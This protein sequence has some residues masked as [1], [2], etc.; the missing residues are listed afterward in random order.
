MHSRKPIPAR[1]STIIGPPPPA[2]PLATAV[3][4]RSGLLSDSAPLGVAEF[5]GLSGGWI[6]HR[7]KVRRGNED[8]C[9]M[10]SG[11]ID[12]EAADCETPTEVKKSTSPWLV[13]VS[14]GI[15]GHLAGA[16]ASRAV[17]SEI[18]QCELIT[19]DAI[20]KQIENLNKTLCE[21]GMAD[22]A[23]ASMGATIAGLGCGPTGLFMFHV[24]DSRIYREE[25]GKLELLTRDDSEAE[26]LID[27]GLLERS[28]GKRPGFLH[29]LTQAVGGRDEV[30]EIDVHVQAIAVMRPTRFLICT[31]GLTDMIQLADMEHLI[32]G[33]EGAKEQ[34]AALFAGAMEAGG[35][36][37]ITIAVVDVT[38][39]EAV[40]RGER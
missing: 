37:N 30:L 14:D 3:V 8:A 33:V 25:E 34:V 17:V 40:D 28:E 39:L 35:Q 13:A 20:K 24:G 12:G 1:R 10:G 38:P 32:Q 15:G 18:G 26:D 6:C 29:A 11:V 2:P 19:Q 4:E 16:E 36:D 27:Q 5:Y 31:D 22:K 9:W 21:R 7:G 23:F